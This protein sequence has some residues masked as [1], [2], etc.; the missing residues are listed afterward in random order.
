MPAGRGPR[1]SMEE[2]APPVKYCEGGFRESEL[3]VITD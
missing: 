3:A 1:F 2:K